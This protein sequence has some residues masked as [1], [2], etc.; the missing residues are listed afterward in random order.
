[1]ISSHWE[2][3][4]DLLHKRYQNAFPFPHII[5]DNFLEKACA[6][7][8]LEEFPDPRATSEWIYYVHVN[9]K[10]LGLNKYH[11]FPPHI[12]STVEALNTPRFIAFLSRLTGVHG[13]EADKEL[14]GGGLHQ[15]ER[16]G[17]LNIH[18]DFTVHPHRRDWRRRVNVLIYFNKDWQESYGGHLELWDKDMK[19]CVQKIAPLFNRCVIFN[20]DPFSFHGHPEPLA[21]PVDRQRKSLALY[22]FTKDANSFVRST[23]YRSRPHERVVIRLAIWADKMTLRMYDAVKR[24]LGI[25]DRAISKILRFLR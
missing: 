2:T 13:L 8:F 10:K 3:T 18:A 23:E 11:L 1:M 22:Y 25:S 16:G 19:Q 4:V 21:C 24:R 17:F 15:I 12:R 9:E 14:E 6:E 7:R 20:T 5:L